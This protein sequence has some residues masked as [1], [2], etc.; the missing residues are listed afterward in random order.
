VLNRSYRELARHFGFKIDPTPPYSPE[1]KGK[2]ESGV[3]YVKH[4]FM[5]TIGDERDIDVLN[6]E[7]DRWVRE[8]AGPRRH[9]TTHRQP[10]DH[11]ET[12]E[13]E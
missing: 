12:V 9:G 1:K 4:N 11:V 13:R 3:R 6:R 2:V 7:L 5:K 10:R 8:I